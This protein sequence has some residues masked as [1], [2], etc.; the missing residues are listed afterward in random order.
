[1]RDLAESIG[2]AL[3]DL[4]GI[5]VA[6]QAPMERTTGAI[7]PWC[8]IRIP[9]W[10]EM[11][12]ESTFAEAT[13]VPVVAA[14]DAKLA[15]L[16]EWTWGAGRGVDDFLYVRASEGVSGGIILNGEIYDGGNGMAGD[17]GHVALEGGGEVCYCGSRGCLTTLISER[18]ILDAVRTSAGTKDS[19]RD[20]L[21]AA[22]RGDAACQRVL[23][24]AGNHLGRALA[25]AAKVMAPSVIAVGGELGA[26]GPLL[27]GG[28]ISSIELSNIR[29]S[30]SSPEFVPARL[31][32]DAAQLGGL[33]AILR[34]VGMG[35]SD[36]EPWM[37]DE[38]RI[39]SPV[40][41]QV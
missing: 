15:A 18:A 35:Q 39:G 37:T 40:L 17:L 23:A 32:A 16:A 41:A 19:L 1:M 8:N 27:F 21:D 9:N 31:G 13:G 34:H 4:D 14:N 29:A 7:T 33:V 20:V 36:L 6:M 11:P 25:N 38:D 3:T 28:L 24:E 10:A 12:I 22:R 5:A 2:V 30:A 26:A